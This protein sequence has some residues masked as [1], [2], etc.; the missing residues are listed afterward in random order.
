MATL[1]IK[2]RTITAATEAELQAKIDAIVA[3]DKLAEAHR[4]IG[5][6]QHKDAVLPANI[7]SN[8]EGQR[9][10]DEARKTM[11]DRMGSQATRAQGHLS[12]K[13]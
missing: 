11:I 9:S 7:P 3:E 13:S 1:K 4:F 5:A 2:G 8:A 12:K 6:Q 10:A